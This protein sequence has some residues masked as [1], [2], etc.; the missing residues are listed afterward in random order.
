MD[1]A[2]A[3]WDSLAR[4]RAAAPLVQ[5]ITNYVAMD[6]SANLLLAIGAAPAMIHAEDEA[7]EFAALASALVVNI[8]TLSPPWVRAMTAAARAA[9]SHGKP[10][11]L[12]PV[13]CG[14]TAYRTAAA[15]ELL[16]LRPTLV[17]GN[18]S[19]ILALAGHNRVA[20]RG[21]DSTDSADA[22]LG[23]A[24][25]LAAEQK[26]VVAI[27][28]A[29]DYVTDGRRHMAIEGG[30]PLMTRV[31]AMGC[32]LSAISAAFLAV[33]PDPLAASAHALALFGLAGA[34]AA[35]RSAGP[36]ELRWRMADM[37]YGLDE[38]AVREGVRIH[39]S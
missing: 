16:A 21:V 11:V 1:H 36:G 25:A 7:A 23:I 5:N 33:T 31:T 9:A 18:A 2:A 10:W 32:A 35:A 4:L 6:L 17:R 24:A 15:R 28:G 34:R 19:E 27:T 39:S 26:T 8:G 29:V 22:V 37:L 38:P 14:A 3:A 12:D 13:G 30:D 20:T